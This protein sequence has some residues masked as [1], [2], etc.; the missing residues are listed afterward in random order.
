VQINET[1][2]RTT[3]HRLLHQPLV[4]PDQSTIVR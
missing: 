4:K 3:E 1:A 2:Y